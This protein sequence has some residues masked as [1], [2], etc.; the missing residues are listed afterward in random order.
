MTIPTIL[1]AYWDD[2]DVPPS[3]ANCLATWKEINPDWDVHILNRNTYTD[4]IDA[5]DAHIFIQSLQKKTNV[6]RVEL[7][8]KYGGVWCDASCI[9]TQP[10]TDFLRDAPPDSQLIGFSTP[11]DRTIFENWFIAAP[12]DS[13]IIR[14][15][16]DE[17]LTLNHYG[18]RGESY[19]KIARRYIHAHSKTVPKALRPQLPYLCMHLTWVVVMA[20]HPEL[21][22][23]VVM[24]DSRVG[25]FK[26]HVQA[27]WNDKKLHKLLNKTTD[28]PQP[29]IKLRGS[30]RKYMGTKHK[31]AF[32]YDIDVLVISLHKHPLENLKKLFPRS[33]VDLQT[34][35]DLRNV[36]VSDLYETGLI[37]QAGY[38][39]ITS[40]RKRHSELNS[41]GG[42]GLAHA[43][44]LALAK[45]PQ[46]PL[47]LLEDDYDIKNRTRF[48][49]QM[50]ILYEHMDRFDLATF[51][52]RKI[53]G[54]VGKKV[55][56]MPKG[57]YHLATGS[58][59]INL[60]AVVYSVSGR[61]KVAQWLAREPLDMQID[62]LYSLWTETRGLRILANFKARVVTQKSHKSTIQT[63]SLI[64][65]KKQLMQVMQTAQVNPRPFLTAIVIIVFAALLLLFVACSCKA[66]RM[67]RP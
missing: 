35:V 10:M 44:R 65:G 22:S 29:F 25:P 64:F 5:V 15:W 56:V 31:L 11:F 47:L 9:M 24:H 30:E 14:L 37:G 13:Q 8:L 40:G 57:W 12:R 50:Q 34:A 4:F 18:T 16:R 39:T 58:R 59:F 49:K 62:S 41:K 26:L 21:A 66:T 55:D 19:D 7:L 17:Y 42:V 6:I 60:H 23:H 67:R 46:R 63:D 28:L 38:D 61:Q 48:L 45:D 33:R 2:P 53:K 3:V 52:A 51:G 54:V 36:D 27:R 20:R 1:W 43:N 32:P